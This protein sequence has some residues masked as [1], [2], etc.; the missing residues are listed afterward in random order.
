MARRLFLPLAS[1]SGTAERP[2]VDAVRKRLG[3][4]AATEAG[5][6]E[7]VG[8]RDGRIGAVL[9]V[10]GEQLDVWTEGDVVRR[11][12]R[13]E[14]SPAD[15]VIPPDVLAVAGEARAFADLAEGQ[16]VGFQKD[17]GMQSGILVEKCRFGALIELET[18]VVVGVAFRRVTAL[19]ASPKPQ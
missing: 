15:G 19:E 17:G 3:G 12:R 4:R 10:R 8:L 1:P 18:G 9:F 2:T 7:L 6:G 14:A 16:R 11:I 5:A 13:G